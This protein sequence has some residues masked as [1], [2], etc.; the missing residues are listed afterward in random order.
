MLER[1]VD[2]E[3]QLLG[4]RVVGAAVHFWVIILEEVAL[5][6]YQWVGDGGIDAALVDVSILED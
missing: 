5:S 4:E 2:A 3:N 1:H 6:H